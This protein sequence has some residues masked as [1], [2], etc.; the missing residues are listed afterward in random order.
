MLTLNTVTIQSNEILVK[1]RSITFKV[2]QSRKVE[3]DVTS[4][5]SSF[6]Y[7]YDPCHVRLII[8]ALHDLSV[9]S[10][11]SHFCYRFS[12]MP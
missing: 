1:L 6:D 5:L 11:D 7:Y 9:S 10:G 2:F 4:I 12:F 3:I 8:M